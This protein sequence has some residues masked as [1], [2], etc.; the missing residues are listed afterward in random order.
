MKAAFNPKCFYSKL[1][2]C[3]LFVKLCHPLEIILARYDSSKSSLN[4]LDDKSIQEIYWSFPSIEWHECNISMIK[5]CILSHP[6][7]LV[8]LDISKAFHVQFKIS[9]I[10]SE[11]S[12][13]HLVYQSKFYYED[14]WTYSLIR[15]QNKQLDALLA[16]LNTSIGRKEFLFLTRQSM[17][18]EIAS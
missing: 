4:A 14:E 2:L 7:S 17:S 6:G 12:L 9:Q 3:F 10:C 5:D 16:L 13:V 18:G 8:L 11:L 1:F 15:Q